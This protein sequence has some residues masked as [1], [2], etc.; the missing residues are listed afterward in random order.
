MGNEEDGQNELNFVYQSYNHLNA[1]VLK[2]SYSKRCKDSAQVQKEKKYGSMIMG[3][4]L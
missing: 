1:S 3:Y 4:V 2:T